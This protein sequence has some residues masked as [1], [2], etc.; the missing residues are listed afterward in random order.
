MVRDLQGAKE[1]VD[2][3]LQRSKIQLFAGG[4][5]LS[6]DA[7]AALTNLGDN[8]SSESEDDD[9]SDDEGSENSD[10]E[11]SSS[12]D[13]SEDED[14]EEKNR[15]RVVHSADGRVRRRAVFPMGDGAANAG[16]GPGG[17]VLQ[18]ES[19]EDSDGEASGD[20]GGSSDD[21]APSGSDLDGEDGNEEGLGAAAR[22]KHAML[23]RASALF[24]TRAAD[25]QQY[26]YG[27]PADGNPSR[28]DGF[29][30]GAAGAGSDDDDDDDLFRLKRAGAKK[31][32][33]AE[34]STA[35]GE[36]DAMDT[37]RAPVPPSALEHWAEPQ[38]VEELRNRFVTGEWAA[39]EA[40]G[41]ARPQEDGED[42]SE[43]A[44]RGDG[45]DE[46]EV[47]GDFEDLETGQHFAGSSDPAT[48]AAAAA[49]KAAEAEDLAA[50]KAAKKAAFNTEYDESG[51]G[52]GIKDGPEGAG[53]KKAAAAAEEEEEETY[54][55]AMKREMT[56]RALKTKA[57]M[58]D[59]DPVQRVAM[60]V[61]TISR[62]VLEVVLAMEGA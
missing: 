36:L 13:G 45:S 37:S 17:E 51:G 26:I 11:D 43:G 38:A 18:Y 48:R 33:A 58:D 28:G 23:E 62:T 27:T 61:S 56:E 47:Y 4:N 57:V 53:A 5:A 29:G 22:W 19:D 44:V 25:L 21:G 52:K 32:Q 46:D 49:I 3:A 54:Y 35:L 24:S 20:E 6:G 15:H 59:L 2:E 31:G 41:A 60:E 9:T 12:D 42:G 14:E 39:G 34:A 1:A 7:A 16:T 40:R 30:S 8:E 50:K 55:D 10:G